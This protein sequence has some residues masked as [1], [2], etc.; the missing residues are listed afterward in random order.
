M[1]ASNALAHRVARRHLRRAEVVLRDLPQE[2]VEVIY[3]DG[4]IISAADVTRLLS[5]KVGFLT[6][7]RFRPSLTIDP[8]GVEWE[9]LN[10]DGE[11]V[12]GT[13]VL[14]DHHRWRA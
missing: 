12:A 11:L 7:M 4:G 9:A 13:L 6:K 8:N 5:D 10:E 14:Q 2:T 1:S 3:S